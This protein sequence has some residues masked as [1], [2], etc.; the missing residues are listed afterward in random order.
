[1]FD[2]IQLTFHFKINYSS[3]RWGVSVKRSNQEERARNYSH[4]DVLTLDDIDAVPFNHGGNLPLSTDDL[5]YSK[6]ATLCLYVADTSSTEHYG[7]EPLISSQSRY[8][9]T[10]RALIKS[11]FE[12]YYPIGNGMVFCADEANAPAFFNAVDR[13]VKKARLHVDYNRTGLYLPQN[14]APA[15]QRKSVAAIL[16]AATITEVVQS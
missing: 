6:P 13:L 16:P 11:G 1:M 2:F 8:P 7:H 4:V 14:Y 5:T 10:N 12:V 15:P 3:D 9:I